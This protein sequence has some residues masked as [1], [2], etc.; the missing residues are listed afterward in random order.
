MD[1]S[2]SG[3]EKEVAGGGELDL[4]GAVGSRVRK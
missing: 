4:I 2:G 3:G 1:G